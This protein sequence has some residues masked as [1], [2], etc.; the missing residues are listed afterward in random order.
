M[1]LEKNLNTPRS[2][3]QKRKESESAAVRFLLFVGGVDDEAGLDST[4]VVARDG[5]CLMPVGFPARLP[6]GRKGHVAV[7]GGDKVSKMHL[8]M[9]L[10]G[11]NMLKF[12]W[13]GFRLRRPRP[14]SGGNDISL[15]YNSLFPPML[16]FQGRRARDFIR[17]ENVF[18]L[19]WQGRR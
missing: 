15:R 5:V 17:V 2:E 19:G 13:A 8:L 4:E 16:G 10:G 14:Q 11:L 18:F 3:K 12:N 7:R 1:A 6:A 9:I